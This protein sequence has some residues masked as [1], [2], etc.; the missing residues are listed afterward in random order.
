MPAPTVV[1]ATRSAAPQTVPGSCFPVVASMFEK[2]RSGLRGV[3]SVS[4]RALTTE[5]ARRARI[6]EWRLKAEAVLVATLESI[7]TGAMMKCRTG[8]RVAGVPVPVAQGVA[9][10]RRIPREAVVNEWLTRYC[11]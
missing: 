7:N 8:E 5:R 6:G 3:D 1:P 4:C 10:H 11:I 9:H 2:S